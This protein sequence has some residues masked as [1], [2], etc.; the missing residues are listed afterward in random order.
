MLWGQEVGYV[1]WH[2][3]KNVPY[4]VYS[5]EFCKGNV[6][7]APL[8]APIKVVGPYNEIY[9]DSSQA[10]F[11]KLPSFI[12][13]S[14]PDAW[15]EHVFERYCD[16]HNIPLPQVNV[17]DKLSFIGQRLWELWSLSLKWGILL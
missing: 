13:D 12:A 4:F 9:S 16:A 6:D 8:V 2:N 11:H 5:E 7:I 10:I 14:L 17:L 1:M 15:G 3:R